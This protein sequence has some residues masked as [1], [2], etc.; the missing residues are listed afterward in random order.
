MPGAHRKNTKPAWEFYDL[1]KD[2]HENHNAYHNPEYSEIISKLK[3]EMIDLRVKLGDTD[4]EFPEM[5][6]ILIANNLN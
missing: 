4:E 6:Q 5:K 2:A 1:Q 3:N